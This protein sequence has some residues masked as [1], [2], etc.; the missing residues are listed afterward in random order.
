M[1]EPEFFVPPGDT[2]HNYGGAYP[3]RGYTRIPREHP[4]RRNY[5]TRRCDEYDRRGRWIA[6]ISYFLAVLLEGFSAAGGLGA[7]YT[8]SP[9]RA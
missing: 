9:G 5:I 6:A 1:F 8:T 7:T 2:F 4:E 3:A